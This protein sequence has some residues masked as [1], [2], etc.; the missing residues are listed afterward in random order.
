MGAA[1]IF[2]TK[3]VENPKSLVDD[4]LKP[5]SEIH[6]LVGGP[7]RDPVKDEDHR[8]GHTALRV[9]TT[10][11]DYIYDFGRYGRTSG[12]FG[13]SGEGILRVWNDFA[14]Y[15]GAENALKRETLGFVYKIHDHQ[16]VAINHYFDEKI[17]AGQKDDRKS[18]TW[19]IA[20]K[21]KTD[22]HALGPNCTTLSIDG[23]KIGVPKIDDGSTLFNRPEEVLDFKEMIALKMHG[24]STR[25]FMPANLEKFLSSPNAIKPTRVERYGGAR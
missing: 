6:L 12:A 21:L 25:L 24:G 1:K 13:E 8:Y 16:A 18:K 20:Y 17:R 2:E 19:M 9:K 11:S 23:A 5:L 10:N 15:I 7:Y 14:K 4:K 22:Y 3:T